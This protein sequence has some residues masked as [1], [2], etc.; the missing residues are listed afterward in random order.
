MKWKSNLNPKK[1][2][3][4]PFQ[5]TLITSP[6]LD[7]EREEVERQ[8]TLATRLMTSSSSD[9]QYEETEG[10]QTLEE[11]T[12]PLQYCVSGACKLRS[13]TRLWLPQPGEAVEVRE[14][15]EQ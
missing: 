7:S 13:V 10:I 15:V 2:Q 1:K 11:T 12:A 9:T 8:V 6:L 4:Q 3:I 14:P 5:C